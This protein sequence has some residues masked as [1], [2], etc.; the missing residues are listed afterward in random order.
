MVVSFHKNSQQVTLGCRSKV[1]C[2]M[3]YEADIKQTNK[4]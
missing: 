2:S 4:A 1:V 3:E